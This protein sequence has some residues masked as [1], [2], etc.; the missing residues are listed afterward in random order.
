MN[1]NPTKDLDNDRKT[2]NINI[3]NTN[4]DVGV[5][6]GRGGWGSAIAFLVL[7]FR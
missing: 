7:P 1:F 5:R 4:A 2:E 3:I 6:D